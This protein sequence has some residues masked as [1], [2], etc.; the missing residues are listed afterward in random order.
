[1]NNLYKLRTHE[2]SV[3]NPV[4]LFI[5]NKYILL[6]IINKL[7]EFHRKLQSE[8]E[9][10]INLLETNIRKQVD[11]D[12]LNILESATL[13]E[14]II[15]D[16]LTDI[17][18]IHY[19]SRW[20]VSNTNQNDLSQRLGKQKEREKQA[21]VHTL[22]TMGDEKRAST[23]ELQKMGITNQFK[24]SAENNAEYQQ[25]EEHREATDVERYNT[26]NTLFEGTSLETYATNVFNGELDESTVNPLI[27]VDEELGYFNENDIDED[28]QMGDEY[29]EYR[30]IRINR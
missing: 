29:H 18:Q 17:L 12:E 13:T 25:S 11:Y 21:Y 16:L 8:D 4:T 19:D 10:V 20:V 1:M 26:M 15:M 5:L 24:A 7:V 2:F 22:D 14:N 30:D 23:M 9:E 3:I 27:P 28:G 6:F